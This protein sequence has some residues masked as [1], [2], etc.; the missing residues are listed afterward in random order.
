MRVR[1]YVQPSKSRHKQTRTGYLGKMASTAL[2]RLLKISVYIHTNCASLE[3][4]FT[5]ARILHERLAL[6]LASLKCQISLCANLEH[7]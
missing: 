3:L 1:F 4:N 2:R 6:R 7:E 5:I